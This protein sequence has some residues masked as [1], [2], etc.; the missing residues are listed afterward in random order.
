MVFGGELRRSQALG[1]RSVEVI[2]V[3]GERSGRIAGAR[4]QSRWSEHSKL[5][6]DNDETAS[7][8]ATQCSGAWR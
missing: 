1:V 6:H 3:V 2:A 4:S 8:F 5:I 7:M